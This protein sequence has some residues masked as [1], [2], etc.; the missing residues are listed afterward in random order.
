[1]SGIA[2]KIVI[3]AR[4]GSTRLP[5]KVLL[6]VA[7]KPVIRHVWEAARRAGAGEIV[8]ATDSEE[9]VTACSAFGADVQLTSAGH[10]SGTDRSNE[11]ARS[12]D[13]PA[14]TVVV[15]L[16]GDEPLMPPALLRQAA[17]L[18]ADDREA[19]IATLCHPLHAQDEWQNP[20]VVKV[21]LDRRGYA[22]YFSRAPIPWPR[23]QA[24]AMPAGLAYRHIG[25]YAYRVAAL[26]EFSS[27]PPAPLETCE[28][29][30]QLRALTHG[31]RIKVGVIDVPPPRG[32]DTADDLRA[33]AALLAQRDARI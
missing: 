31:Y 20:N 25:L 4:L 5:R 21:V 15:N 2:F 10:Q 26:A 23:D 11:I 1:M 6:E 18:L 24:P 14:D 9:V 29:L 12:R 7:G 27:L 33:V 30:E 28:A 8:V 22:L 3:P 32:V 16:Q 13:W 19:H 17:A